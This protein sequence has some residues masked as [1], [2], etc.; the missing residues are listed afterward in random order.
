[1]YGFSSLFK[2]ERPSKFRRLHLKENPDI[3]VVLEGLFVL[4]SG[5]YGKR[6]LNFGSKEIVL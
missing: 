4:P 5:Y 2:A 1:L 6:R 3:I